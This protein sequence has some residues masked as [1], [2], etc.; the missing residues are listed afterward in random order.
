MNA[1]TKTDMSARAGNRT[2]VYDQN[3]LKIVLQESFKEHYQQ[4]REN[5]GRKENTRSS[6]KN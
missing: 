5:E 1:V 2:P 3:K 4:L 6:G